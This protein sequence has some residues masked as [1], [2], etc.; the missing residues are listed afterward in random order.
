MKASALALLL[1][2]ALPLPL[3]A[4]EDPERELLERVAA[5]VRPFETIDVTYRLQSGPNWEMIQRRSREH[6]QVDVE[7]GRFRRE[8]IVPSANRL[9]RRVHTWDGQANRSFEDRAGEEL[10]E[11][12]LG[13]PLAAGEGWIDQ[14]Q[15]RLS[16]PFYEIFRGTRPNQSLA[17][18]IL[19]SRTVRVEGNAITLG[20]DVR[21]V[22]DPA[23]GRLLSR[24]DIALDE[25]GSPYPAHFIAVEEY[26]EIGGRAFPVRVTETWRGADTK[27]AKV[28]KYT[29]NTEKLKLD[30]ALSADTFTLTF[31]QGSSVTDSILKKD[32]TVGGSGD[33]APPIAALE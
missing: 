23:T 28:A 22:I 10:D 14:E 7:T 16:A 15:P 6:L 20:N 18:L 25:N 2:F 4:Q 8:E 21:L 31:P 24:E 9:V 11:V 27:V 32:Y 30:E 29:V 26:A 19:G 12:R 33:P 3:L 5:Q 1:A 13:A 17:E